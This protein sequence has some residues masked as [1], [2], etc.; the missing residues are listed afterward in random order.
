MHEIYDLC[1][2]DLKFDPN[3]FYC[4]FNFFNANIMKTYQVSGDLVILNAVLSTDSSEYY[5]SKIQNFHNL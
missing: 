3:S 2:E 5:E 4:F 1:T